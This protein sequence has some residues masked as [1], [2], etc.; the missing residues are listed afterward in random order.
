MTSTDAIR[1]I[2]GTDDADRL[3]GDASSEII[4]G[5]GGDDDLG[6]NSGFDTVYGG[7]GD[8][9]IDGGAGNDTLY[10]GGGPSWADMTRLS[11]AEDY[12]GRI[13]FLGESAGFRNVL[14]MYKVDQDGAITDVS[15]LFPN[16]SSV[17]SGGSLVPGESFVDVAL[18][19]GDQ[20]GF[21][22]IPDGFSRN[23]VEALTTGSL[24]FVDNQGDA[25]MLD[26]NGGLRLVRTA[27]DGSQSVIQSRYGSA[28]FHSAAKPED[29][30]ELND[31]NY[32][33]TVGH[34][35]AL[36]GTITLGFEDLW[37]GGDHDYDD[38]VFRFDVGQSNARVLDPNIAQVDSDD[39]KDWV[40]GVDGNRY[41]LQGKL[42]ASENDTIH[43]GTGDDDIFGM[44]GNDVLY[45][46]D[47][48]D[49][50]YGNS[51]A[52]IVEGGSG[53]DT[54][55][56]GKGNDT[57]RGGNGRDTLTGN[58]GDD[59]LDGGG[60]NDV[61]DGS[62]GNDLLIGGYNDD[63]LTGG[64]GNDT[65]HGDSGTDTLSGGKGDDVLHGGSGDDQLDG[66]TGNDLIFG[67]TGDDTIHGGS[68]DDV[69]HGEDGA[70][71]INGGSGH[72]RIDGGAGR[73]HILSGSG[74]D[75][76]SGGD[77][78]DYISAHTG[79]DVL[80]GGAGDDK[81]AM[82]KGNDVISGGFG[83]DRFVFRAGD[84]DGSTDVITDFRHDGVENDWIDIRALNLSADD[85]SITYQE[86]GVMLVV[87]DTT[88]RIEDHEGLGAQAFVAQVHD[89]LLLA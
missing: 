23:S 86:G 45:G 14:G 47:G 28:M 12:T 89:G 61:L 73:D 63:T 64:T 48:H 50:M 18:T 56:G 80:S 76:V 19:A 8:D 40:Y 42:I 37:A 6:G 65:L 58:S 75:I 30:Y 21:F 59:I 51:G 79:D 9:R 82:G 11:I 46:G 1:P 74:D 24:A 16:A 34:V 38:V 33:H 25:A 20:I 32:A 35:N 84:L 39:D 52:D 60:D 70:D 36:D 88:I 78:N 7:S 2:I 72:D 53:N 57:L 5:R 41:D 49:V 15:V 69:I 55:R 83:H 26:S 85:I 77:G 54:L 67:G 71:R 87:G 22:V 43:G 29:R 62:D 27:P 81:I 31:D 68:H 4:S 66:D 3:R 44:A 13:T 10:G 17:G